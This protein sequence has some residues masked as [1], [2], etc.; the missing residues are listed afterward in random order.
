MI[1]KFKITDDNHLVLSNNGDLILADQVSYI[2]CQIDISNSVFL[3]TDTLIAVFKS[4]T[5]NVEEEVLLAGPY[6]TQKNLCYGYVPS[7][8]FEHG[9]TIQMLVY[10]YRSMAS[11][12]TAIQA[13][14]DTVQFYLD[15]AKYVPF[16]T[17]VMWQELANEIAYL[18]V[19][20]QSDWDQN[21]SNAPDFIKNKPSIPMYYDENLQRYPIAGFFAGTDADNNSISGLWLTYADGDQEAYVFIPDYAGMQIAAA[22]IISMIPTTTQLIDLIYPVGSY[23]ETSDDNFD[24]NESWIGTWELSDG[25]WHRVG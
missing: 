14:T 25:K 4:A 5:Y 11:S 23:Y 15:P 10:C 9:G 16:R 21:I 6:D 3:N 19:P 8:V 17:D 24:P 12:P 20:I 22:S 1:L 7:K 18:K 2:Q 13:S